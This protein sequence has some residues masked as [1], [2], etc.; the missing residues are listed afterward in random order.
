MQA[1]AVTAVLELFYR[2]LRAQRGGMSFPCDADGV[3]DLDTLSDDDRR[4]YLYARVVAGNE[5][6]WPVVRP[7]LLH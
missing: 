1:D 7:S 6:A 3:V 5:F 2:P 4:N